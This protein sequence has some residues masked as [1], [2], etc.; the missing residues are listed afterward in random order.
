MNFAPI[1]KGSRQ[2]R[3]HAPSGLG[4]VSV[5][6]VFTAVTAQASGSQ[7][8]KC[9]VGLEPIREADTGMME[10]IRELGAK[11][12]DPDGCVVCHGG[13]PSATTA[14][15]AHSGSTFYPD[16]GSP[17]VNEKTCGQCHPRHVKTQWTSLMM[18]E[19]GKIQG[20]AWAFGALEGG[21]D[22]KWGN[23][24]VQN[25]K[26]SAERIGTDQYRAYMAAL[27]KKEPQAFPDALTELPPA[28]RD[29]ARLKTHPEEAAFTYIRDQCDRCHWAVRGRKTR[30]DYRGMGCS[31]CHI[32][33]GTEGLYEGNDP[34]I[35]KDMPG[36][37][38][39]HSI[40]ATRGAKV[41]VHGKTYTGIPTETCA[42][43]H[44]R[45][46]R[47]GVS[48]Q[49]LM[50]SAF[51]SP[52]TEGGGGQLPLHTKHYIAM[53]ED[54]HARK[55]MLCQDCHTSNDV[56][57]DG[58]LAGSNLG[59]VEIECSD[60]H[61]TPAAYP[62]EL[63]LGYMD[64]FDDAP[65][66]GPARGTANALY[67]PL[68]QGTVNPVED[69]YLITAR[70]N[71]LP[72]S[73]RRGNR[74]VVHA[75]GGKDLELK[76]LKLLLAEN[77]LS[78]E[79]KLAMSGV[80]A[81][82]KKMECYACHDTWAPQCYGCHVKVDYSGGK[83]GFDWT[84]A[85]HVHARSDPRGASEQGYDCAIPG[86]TSEQRSYMRWEDPIL[87]VNGEGRVSPIIP[88]CQVSVT[89]IDAD[90]NDVVR[91]KIYRTPPGT[92]GSGP[93]GQLS[94]DMS[95]AQ[96]H[97]VQKRARSC[98][99]CHVSEKALGYGIAGGRLTRAWDKPQFVELSDAD[100]HILSEHARPQTEPIAGLTDDWSRIVTEDG[101]QLM[102]VGHHFTRSR[103]LND[104]ERANM[105]RAG[106]CQSCHQEIPAG[107]LAVG[108]LHHAGEMAGAL[109]RDPAGHAT[110]VRK[111]LLTSAWAQVGGALGACGGL[112]M[113][114]AAVAARRR[115]RTREDAPTRAAAPP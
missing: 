107:S 22:H 109:P 40:Q 54:V 111:V 18:T 94:L 56:H 89:V 110:L 106:M 42:V 19:A 21:Y 99:S 85:G 79:G 5:L 84:E 115:R 112:G 30:G 17:W 44:N 60:C 65:K 72:G 2:R 32:P 16:P 67:S 63:P 57:G 87:G 43:C 58:F 97:T 76:P 37:L 27:R 70:G 68:E 88:G 86:Q 80:A 93:G 50:E 15:A 81:H 98:E 45:G 64:E 46:K 34:N 55:G 36:H 4:V 33:Y 10:R 8:A 28:P 105:S 11:R 91:N 102:T 69:G 35:P 1:R 29:L 23:Y 39:V 96:T 66:E 52:C 77:A 71:P 61:G 62:W 6:A 104:A 53:Q 12:G 114:A 59:A 14:A 82:M 25:P 113:L 51:E 31:A 108:A 103:P 7:C 9:H 13:D 49:G 95:P 26:D 83:K 41:T 100:G 101:K 75:A 20:T 24:D 47:I 78:A 73:V 90:G 48:F 3:G 38:L 74:V 92:E